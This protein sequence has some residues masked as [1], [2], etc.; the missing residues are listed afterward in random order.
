MNLAIAASL[1][2][3]MLHPFHSMRPPSFDAKAT[4]QVGKNG[5]EFDACASY[6]KVAIK[7]GGAK[8]MARIKP[9]PSAQSRTVDTLSQN[10]PFF[11]CDVAGDGGEWTGIIYS[12]DIEIDCG[13]G[14]PVP[15]QHDYT[16]PCRSGWIST[17]NVQ[18][19]A[20]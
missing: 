15:A 17:K 5:P 6:G 2:V 9:N 10:D 7:D 20:G 13:A 18:L 14:S 4:V 16:G 3:A 19:I 12:K 8:A 11:M 1:A